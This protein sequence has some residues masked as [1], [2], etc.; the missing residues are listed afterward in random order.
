MVSQLAKMNEGVPGGRDRGEDG[1]R[2]FRQRGR[3]RGA[4]ARRRRTWTRSARFPAIS[5][6]PRSRASRRWRGGRACRSSASRASQVHGGAVAAVSRDYYD[7]GREAAKLAA[8]VMRGESPS[9]IPFVPFSENRVA[10]STSR[11]RRRSAWRPPGAILAKADQVRRAN[12]RM[13]ITQTVTDDGILDV[14]VEGRLDGYWSDHLERVAHRGDRQRPSS[15][16]ARLLGAHLPEL[17]RP[18]RAGEVP[19]AARRRSTAR[20]RSSTRRSRSA[21]C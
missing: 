9:A 7:S 18:R 4:R 6:R 5:R 16:P 19:P 20:S 10:S 2:E 14:A 21:P 11:R 3:R 13:E 17:R 15:H 12:R 1:R 8:R